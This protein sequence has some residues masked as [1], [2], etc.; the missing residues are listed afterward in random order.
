MPEVSLENLYTNYEKGLEALSLE[1]I[2]SLDFSKKKPKRRGKDEEEKEYRT[3]SKKG[4]RARNKIFQW[5]NNFG[6]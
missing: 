4:N 1:D 5:L 3:K 2:R 6:L